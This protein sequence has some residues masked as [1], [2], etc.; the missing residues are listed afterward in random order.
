MSTIVK[1]IDVDV[2]VSV[3]YNQWTQFERFPQFME[4]VEEVHQLDDKTLHW[5][6]TI[7]GV[8][9]EWRA[10]IVHQVPDQIIAWRSVEGA[11]NDGLVNFEADRMNA[12]R[13]TVRVTI[14]F[15]PDDVLGKVADWL[16]I[17]DRRTEGDLERFKRLIESQQH[18]DGAWRGEIK[19]TGE[20]NRDHSGVGGLG[21]TTGG[22][23]QGQ[24][25]T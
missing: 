21:G 23:I 5:K 2:P 7:A 18:E 16:N 8:T 10:E 12:N 4:G 19:P 13:C 3:A 11:R 24:H 20:V 1:S 25:H 22:G 15:E 9:R 17:V 6:A 14:E